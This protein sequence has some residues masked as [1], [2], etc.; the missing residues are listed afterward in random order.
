M[1]YEKNKQRMIIRQSSLK[2]AI[3]WYVLR[4][5]QVSFENLL[6]TSEILR[7]YVELGL[8]QS[9]MKNAQ[10]IDEI[11]PVVELGEKQQ[12]YPGDQLEDEKDEDDKWW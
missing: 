5:E 2:S 8:S 12:V 1:D 7:G 4:N 11:Y 6:K 10:K 9:V 3:E